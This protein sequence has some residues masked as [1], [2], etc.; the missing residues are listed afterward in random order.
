MTESGRAKYTCSKMHGAKGFG[1]EQISLK[2]CPEAEMKTASP[3][4]TSRSTWKPKAVMATDSL[5]TTH[6]LA[7]ST[8]R[9]PKIKGR[10]PCG[11]RNA[12]SPYPR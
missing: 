7:P 12:K 3:G 9:R 6:S 1:S 8:S 4:A 10:M 2:R 11:S 5:A